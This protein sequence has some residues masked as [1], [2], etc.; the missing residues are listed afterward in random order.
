[1]IGVTIAAALMALAYVK[2]IY[3]ANQRSKQKR[4][5]ADL[6]TI[7]TAIEAWA[8][9]TREYPVVARYEALVPI[10]EPKYI[11]SLPRVDAWGT[12]Y[13][14]EATKDSYA[15]MSAGRDGVFEKASAKDYFNS[16]VKESFDADIVFANGTFVQ[17]PYGVGRN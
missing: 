8:Q 17:Y 1:M 9:D 11:K 7:G 5:Q 4:T 16:G 2:S 3:P 6:R 12:P 10:L 15:I 14:Y 13:R